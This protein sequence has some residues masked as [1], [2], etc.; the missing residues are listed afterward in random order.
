MKPAKW[1]SMSETYDEYL[2]RMKRVPR[3]HI[4]AILPQRLSK[5]SQLRVEAAVQSVLDALPDGSSVY[6]LIGTTEAISAA[7]SGE[8]ARWEGVAD[9][10]SAH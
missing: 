2:Q 4:T 9:A 8:L 10:K 6:L 7:R 5:I 1:Q 3:G